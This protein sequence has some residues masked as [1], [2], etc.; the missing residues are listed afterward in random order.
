MSSKENDSSPR[1]TSPWEP[2]TSSVSPPAPRGMP[3]IEVTFDIDANGIVNVSA[4]D[5]GTGT[6]QSIKIESQTSL[7]EDEIQAK[8]AE[9]ERF[10]EEDERRKAKIDLRNTAD[11]IVYQTRRTLEEAED[12]IT[13]DQTADVRA[14][15]DDLERLVRDENDQPIELEALDEAAI[16]TKVKDVEEAMHGISAILYEAPATSMGSDQPG[17]PASEASTDDG[18]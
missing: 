10:A 12:K 18:L 11:Q 6:E 17:G 1:T 3:Q 2:S 4:K 5:L 15:L 13:E 16:Q 7:S 8:I 9:A 14:A